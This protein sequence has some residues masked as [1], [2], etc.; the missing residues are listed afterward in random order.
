MVKLIVVDRAGGESVLEAS[1]GSTLMETIRDSGFGD[2][3]AVCG[4]CCSC[5]TCH[6][7]IDP[8]FRSKLP[9]IDPQED[10]L[11]STS[12][13]R[14]ETSRLSCQIVVDQNLDGMR[15]VVAQED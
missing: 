14:D 13:N 10:E 4:G 3:L 11:L 1:P 6:V 5:A 9:E 7:H 8:T 12:L 15:I 2:L